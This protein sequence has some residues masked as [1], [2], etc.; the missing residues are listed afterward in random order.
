MSANVGLPTPRGSGTSGYVQKNLSALRPNTRTQYTSSQDNENRRDQARRKP[1]E[2]ILDHERKREV[3]V[4]CLELRDKLED[5][6]KDEAD[7][8]EEVEGLRRKLLAEME[9]ATG[10]SNRA[11]KGWET[12]EL[13]Q[14]K[15]EQ[16]EKFEIAVGLKKAPPTGP[17][18]GNN[19]GWGGPPP[20]ARRPYNEGRLERDPRDRFRGGGGGG[21]RGGGYQGGRD[22]PM[23]GGD[24]YDGRGRDGDDRGPP[25]R[26]FDQDR[27]PRGGREGPPGAPTGPRDRGF[28]RREPRPRREVD[29][30]IGQGTR[31]TPS[32]MDDDDSRPRRPRGPRRSSSKSPVRSRSPIRR[33]SVGSRSGSRSR[34]RTPPPRRRR[35]STPR[36]MSRTPP[37]RS[38]SPGPARRRSPSRTRPS[39]SR[40]RTPKSASPPPREESRGRSR[41]I[42]KDSR[43]PSPMSERS[44]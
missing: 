34:S 25:P 24:R 22:G 19:S 3:E 17:S 36:S 8:E 29:S 40:S 11:V 18:G 9:N 37:N 6:G 16:N 4:K 42:K 15:L 20:W 7:I 43:S 38:R 5:E 21:P 10:S 27:P 26:H 30:Y 23:R 28:S 13:A 44:D 39:R 35:R 12:H 32:P 41:S 14:R 33:R 2:E 1:N 31:R